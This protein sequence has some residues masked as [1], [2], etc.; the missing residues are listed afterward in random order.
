[1]GVTRREWLK[2][3]LAV[4]GVGVLAAACSDDDTPTPDQGS[5]PDTGPS[6]DGT[7]QDTMA[8]DTA[9][10]DTMASDTATS[11][12]ASGDTVAADMGAQD[13]SDSNITSNHGHSLTVPAADVTA[14]VEKTY[15][16]QGTSNHDHE[17][18]V[19]AADFTTLQGGQTVTISSVTPDSTHEHDVTVSC[20]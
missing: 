15:S 13:C 6:A 3:T 18:K 17:V 9:S 11:D 7:S 10:G 14:G 16:I 2:A 8:S 20:A 5:Q 12:S 19:T 4:A 1:M